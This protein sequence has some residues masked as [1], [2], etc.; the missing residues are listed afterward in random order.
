MWMNESEV[1]EAAGRY[2]EHPV[3][4]PATATLAGL[5]EWTNAN[6]DGWAYWRKP[7]N[8]AS[9]LQDLIGGYPEFRDD[10]E[11]KDATPE[12]YKAALVPLKSF[13]TRMGKTPM[14][15]GAHKGGQLFVIHRPLA[16][17]ESVRVWRAE[18]ACAE[19]Q[20][21]AELADLRAQTA[22]ALAGQA[23]LELDKAREE[24]YL[25][26]LRRQV[27]AGLLTDERSLALA[28]YS[29]GDKLWRLPESRGSDTGFY[30]LGQVVTVTG[31]A[32]RMAGAVL[33]VEDSQGQR[34][35]E[36][37]P[38]S[39]REARERWWILDETGE[40]LVSGGH[41]EQ[42]RMVKLVAERYHGQGCRV[43]HGTDF[44][45]AA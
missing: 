1:E 10:F 26:Q 4:G 33:A 40:N 32:Y 18:R 45:P 29:A 8:A 42:A 22:H 20:E 44:I 12:R 38:M 19:A 11:R 25:D 15:L 3:L 31:L 13:R 23:A 7:S 17:G 2:A 24:A 34:G 6:S 14:G 21:L 36:Y 30:G 39:L 41:P 16:A 9:K 28:A 37:R 27:K 35:N 5:V 43:V